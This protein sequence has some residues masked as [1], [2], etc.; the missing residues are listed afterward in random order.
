M[1]MGGV[2][3][4]RPIHIGQVVDVSARLIHTGR[5]TMHV[6]VHVYAHWPREGT[7]TRL[8][9]AHGLTVLAALD[10]VGDATD[11]LPWAPQLPK[12]VALDLH[13]RELIAIRGRRSPA[14]EHRMVEI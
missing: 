14:A 6:A 12:D 1:Y 9:A 2:R 3:F 7:H 4:Y 10:T 11:V 8:L 5:Q 13:A